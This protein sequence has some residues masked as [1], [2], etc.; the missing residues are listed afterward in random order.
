MLFV[1]RGYGW[2]VPVIGFGA[3]VLSQLAIDAYYGD[4]FYTANAWPKYVASGFAALLI[5]PLGIYLNHIKR[6]NLIDPET[7]EVLGKAPSHSLF[8][9]P[10]EYWAVIIVVLLVWVT[11]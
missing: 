3:L 5:G 10:I 8:F 2:L 4:G 9:I 1:W 6:K 11:R 7:G